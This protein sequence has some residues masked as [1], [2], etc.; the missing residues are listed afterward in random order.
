MF[1]EHPAEEVD[2][3]RTCS[4]KMHEIKVSSIRPMTEECVVM[5]GRQEEGRATSRII[6][7]R[8]SS[9]TTPESETVSRR[10][11][12]SSTKEGTSWYSS[13]FDV[14]SFLRAVTRV[15]RSSWW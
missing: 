11:R 9:S 15:T 10:K 6:T 7:C 14:R 3:G 1:E 12:H 13:K 5:R 8:L 2:V 4:C